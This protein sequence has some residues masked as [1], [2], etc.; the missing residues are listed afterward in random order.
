MIISQQIDFGVITYYRRLVSSFSFPLLIFLFQILNISVMTSNQI[1]S[2]YFLIQQINWDY[3]LLSNIHCRL[4]LFFFQKW[5]DGLN[6][7]YFRCFWEIVQFW[8]K[9][10][11]IF[12]HL[13]LIFCLNYFCLEK[14]GILK[15]L[16]FDKIRSRIHKNE[17]TYKFYAILEWDKYQQFADFIKFV[18]YWFDLTWSCKT[19]VHFF[20]DQTL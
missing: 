1:L 4:N 3:L 10:W 6:E 8:N 9:I 17:L 19:F 5:S 2:V 7:S 20:L 18:F 15:N 14:W 11:T 12:C 13:F 16:F